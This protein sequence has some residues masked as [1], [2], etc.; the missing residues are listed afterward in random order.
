[1]S[2][3]RL[4]GRLV[5]LVA[6]G[7]LC[8]SGRGP[9][10]AALAVAL[11]VLLVVWRVSGPA[12]FSRWLGAPA[13][14]AWRRRWR[15]HRRW[16][17]TLAMCGLTV[18]HAETVHVPGLAKR[19]HSSAFT[20][21]VGVGF[22]TGQTLDDW[23]AAAAALASAFGAHA[24]RVRA[25]GPASAVLDF[26]FGDALREPLPAVP[27]EDTPDL[28]AL[29][30]GR[31]EDGAPWR[32]RLLGT[33][34]LLAGTSGAGKGSV[35]WGLIRALCP[36]IRDGWVQVWAVDP[37]G[38]M[39]L[40][41]GAGLFARFG[42]ADIEHMVTLLEEAVAVM[43]ARAVRLRGV[44]RLHQPTVAEPLLVVVVDELL[45]LTAYGVDNTAK[46]R[47][48]AA[49]GALLSKG[50]AVGVL[51]IGAVQDPRKDSLPFRDL[52]PSRI[53]LRLR[54]PESADLVLGDGARNA[55]A[56]CD[57]IPATAPGV[58][59]VIGDD[60]PEPVRVRAGYVTDA[61]IAA[62][63]EQYRPAPSITLAGVA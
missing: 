33:H 12:S 21:R 35:L 5:V 36:G 62:M 22:V 47:V 55:G 28:A 20:D 48:T 61:D 1:M 60:T 30:I 46:K 2:T 13:R 23:R 16:T 50:R 15:Y 52:F 63:V 45:S 37:K 31:R 32:V 39:E 59:Y 11:P 26:A 34:V 25:T 51:V 49:L 18:K 9:L 24:C 3:A 8:W 43:D 27:I 53:A 17:K 58:G 56:R 7:W 54:E 41:A 10:L 38:G 40:T 19:I 14:S 42:Y 4:L 57:E 6:F 44:T 29:P